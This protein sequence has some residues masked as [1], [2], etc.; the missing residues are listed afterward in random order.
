MDTFY[1]AIKILTGIAILC[2]LCDMLITSEKFKPYVHLIL[3]LAIV[4][5]LAEP[6]A[7]L[8]NS[9]WS[10]SFE[11]NDT[12]T[13]NS[14]REKVEQIWNGYSA[15]SLEKYV[16]SILNDEFGKYSFTVRTYRHENN[17]YRIYV[18]FNDHI[19][20]VDADAAKKLICAKTGISADYVNI[21]LQNH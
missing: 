6:T 2:F 19:N 21:Y 8:I 5:A 7:K 14:Y 13:D 10:V 3:G 16:Q 12:N 15:S 9:D 1:S 20:D 17:V 4:A 11:I 18:T